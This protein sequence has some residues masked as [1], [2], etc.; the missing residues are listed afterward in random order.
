MRLNP[1]GGS[2]ALR[3]SRV[4]ADPELAGLSLAHAAG[5]QRRGAPG[6][7]RRYFRSYGD[8]GRPALT[9]ASRDVAARQGHAPRHRPRKRRGPAAGDGW[10]RSGARP[11]PARLR[12]PPPKAAPPPPALP[13]GSA[14]GTDAE[15]DPRPGPPAARHEKPGPGR[16]V[17]AG[18]RQVLIIL[19]S[20][21]MPSIVKGVNSCFSKSWERLKSLLIIT[22]SGVQ[23]PL[24]RPQKYQMSPHIS[25]SCKWNCRC[26]F[27]AD[28]GIDW[29]GLQSYSTAVSSLL[30]PP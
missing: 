8:C 16:E 22:G 14:S 11:G 20:L 10:V 15:T 7:S 21:Q 24:K 17:G 23:F 30:G 1:A 4:A 3:C 9:S 5:P 28:F 12:A 27:P 19:K 6:A 18:L 29:M 13:V 26:V 2:G 25:S